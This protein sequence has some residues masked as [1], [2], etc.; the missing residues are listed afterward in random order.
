MV[1][2][3]GSSTP[4]ASGLLS[5]PSPA[6]GAT[7]AYLCPGCSQDVRPGVPHVVVWP[8]D[9]VGGLDQ[10]RHWHS[11][12]WGR[13]HPT[14]TARILEATTE[15]IN[16]AG[17]DGQ[18]DPVEVRSGTVLPARR[19]DIE[20]HT[21]DGLTLV[22]ELALPPDRDPVATLVCL[23]PLPT[24]GGF[25]DC[26]VLRKAACRLPA[27]ADLAV[28]RFNTRG[29][30][31]PRGTS[32]GAFDEARPSGSTSRPRSSTPSSTTCR[33]LAARLVVR[34]RPGAHARPRPGGRGRDPAAPPLRFCRR[35]APRRLGRR[36][37]SR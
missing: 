32:E 26:H 16:A 28:L 20:L 17:A 13:P 10:R 30:T 24:H 7:R 31:S 33:T 14:T 36:S 23:H 1:P 12:C 34:H 6:R 15:S 22:G 8:A 29:T 37:A 9:G 21:A 18:D 35:R 5:A 3:G 27:L 25:M 11:A 4:A 2:R 19:E